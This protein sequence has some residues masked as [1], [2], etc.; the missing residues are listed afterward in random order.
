MKSRASEIDIGSVGGVVGS[1]PCRVSFFR[2]IP[3]GV[4]QKH[5]ATPAVSCCLLTAETSV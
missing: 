2:I 1:T 3:P 5:P 4:V